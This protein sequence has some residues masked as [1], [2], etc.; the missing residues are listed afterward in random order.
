LITTIIGFAPIPMANEH[1]ISAAEFIDRPQ[2][3]PR[4]SL[5]AAHMFFLYS[6]TYWLFEGS[7]DYEL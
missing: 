4:E 6:P 3:P 2:W 7:L 1:N 5:A